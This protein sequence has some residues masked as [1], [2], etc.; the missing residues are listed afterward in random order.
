MLG[1]KF[2]IM[3]EP[4]DQTLNSHCKEYFRYHIAAVIIQNL[5][6]IDQRKSHCNKEEKA[7]IQ[8]RKQS[9]SQ[10]GIPSAIESVLLSWAL[11]ARMESSKVVNI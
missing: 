5:H 11:L 10:D 8:T 7:I 3:L 9:Q 4:M 1:E 2:S 6:C